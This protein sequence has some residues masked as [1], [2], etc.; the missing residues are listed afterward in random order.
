MLTVLFAFA[1][2]WVLRYLIKHRM[3]AVLAAAFLLFSLVTRTLSLIYVDL[4]G[5]LYSEQLD[6]MVGGASSMPLFAASILLLM[7]ALAYV[8]RPA[9]LQQVRVPQRP[10]GRRIDVA[11]HVLFA[12]AVVFVV[13]LYGDMLG[14]GVVPLLSAMDRLEYNAKVAGPL[15]GWLVEMGF[16]LAGTL[17][18]GFCMPR[19]QGRDFDFRFLALFLL[20]LTYFALTG[21]RF[22]AFYSFTSFF[23]LPLAAVPAMA[24]VGLLPPH[25]SRSIWKRFVFSKTALLMAISVCVFGILSLLLHSVITVRGYDDPVEQ[26]T[27]RALIQPVE[28]WWIT[29]NDLDRYWSGSFDEA[30]TDL[31]TNPIDP[32]RNTSMQMLMLRNLGY[33]RTQELLDMGQQYTGGYPEV[34]FELLGPWLA[35]PAALTFSVP[36]AILLRMCVLAVCERRLLTAFMAMYVFFGFS[37]L[38]IGGMLNFLVPWTFWAKVTILCLVYIVERLFHA[39]GQRSPHPVRSQISRS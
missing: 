7:A 11:G 25:P 16:M 33:G 1:V 30:W 17:G 29:W 21:N 34:L 15:H 38:F 31:F 24:S 3:A 39:I 20:V 5:P 32:T 9:A 6:R 18:A 14:R 23:I 35:L 4:A 10:A 22:S 2:L 26:L 37:L 27:Q 19:L 36:T 13:S 28:L 8:F 12:I